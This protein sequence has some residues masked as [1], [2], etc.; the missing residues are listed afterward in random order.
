MPGVRATV[1]GFDLYRWGHAM[2]AAEKGF[3]F[4]PARQSAAQPVGRLLFANHNVE[5]LP[6]FE[7][8][9]MAAMRA[10]HEAEALIAA[11]PDTR[12]R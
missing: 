6:A 11:R 10:A 1:T 2:L 9:V 5:G 3:V 12:R 4:S 7:N 8:A